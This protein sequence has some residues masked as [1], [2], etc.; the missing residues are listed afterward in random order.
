VRDP[1]GN[2]SADEQDQRLSNRLS[3]LRLDELLAEV[4]NPLAQISASRAG[5]TACWT[6]WSVLPA[7]WS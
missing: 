7:G 3:G 6:R 1:E 5:C 2:R 4:T